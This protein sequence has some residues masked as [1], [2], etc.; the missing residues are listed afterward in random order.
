MNPNNLNDSEIKNAEAEIPFVKRKSFIF[1]LAAVTAI[2]ATSIDIA[3]PGHP[4][5]G[6]SFGTTGEAAGVIVSAY[7][8]GYGPGQMLWGP[9][10]DKYGR[11]MPLYWGIGGF[12]AVTIL[13]AMATSLESLAFY[14][15]IQGIFGGCGPVIARAI[16]RDQGGGKNTANLMATIMMI[17]GAAPLL[18]PLV[19]SSILLFEHWRFI[20]WFLVAFGAVLMLLAR[21]YIAPATSGQEINKKERV[22]LSWGLIKRLM[23]GHDFVMGSTTMGVIFFGYSAMLGVGAAMTMETYDITAQMFGILFA[24]AASAV[25]MGPAISRKI[26]GTQSIRTPLKLGGWI[27]LLMGVG[28]ALVIRGEPVSLW[29]LWPM[30]FFYVLSFGIMMPIAS[31]IALEDAGDAA[32]TASSL[33]SALPTI[34]AAMGAAIAASVDGPH[35]E[36]IFTNG[37]Q[38]LTIMMAFGGIGAGAVVL[39]F[40]GGAKAET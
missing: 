29:V 14:R 23:T 16:A 4:A 8:L 7:F 39:I 33:L 12:I 40:G 5:I 18:A 22:P 24:I 36:G 25:M 2:T 38:A 11:M 32:G 19:G 1:S 27:A 17:F 9:L 28:F 3:L 26:I 30:V 31:S 10:A 15:F 20:F 34:A 35:G 21:L 6:E 37:Y 13:C